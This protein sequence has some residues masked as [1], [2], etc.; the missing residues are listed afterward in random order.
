MVMHVAH[1]CCLVA[2]TREV[3]V[4]LTARKPVKYISVAVACKVTKRVRV[5]SIRI[6]VLSFVQT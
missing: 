3:L 6:D 5:V 1:A 2:Y 4:Q